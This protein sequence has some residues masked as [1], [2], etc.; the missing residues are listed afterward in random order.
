MWATC[1]SARP[2]F[3]QLDDARRELGFAT[4]AATAGLYRLAYGG[5]RLFLELSFAAVYFSANEFHRRQWISDRTDFSWSKA[6]DRTDGVLSSTFVREFLPD[7]VTDAPVYA[8][9]AEDCYRDCSQFVHGKLAATSRLPTDL[10]FSGEIL[11]DWTTIARSA[12]KAV[13]YLLYCRYSAEL[14]EEHVELHSTL[15]PFTHLRCVRKA[16]GMPIEGPNG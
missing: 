4:F 15:D 6:L 9:L 10:A 14:L 2:E 12:A 5:L 11:S 13:L 1:L 16:L 3:R 8:K 7:A